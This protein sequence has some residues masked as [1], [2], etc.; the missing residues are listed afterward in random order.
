MHTDEKRKL[1]RF[2]F[3]SVLIGVPSVALFLPL[4]FGSTG[5]CDRGGGGRTQNRVVLYTSVDDPVARPILAEFTKRTGIEV[6]LRTDTEANKSAGLVARLEAEKSNPRADVWWGN[7]IFRTINLADRGVL[8]PYESPAA[9]DIPARF[10]DP[11][12]L[13]AGSAQRAR[14]IAL[15]ADAE[16]SPQDLLPND[17]IE[18]LVHPAL[19]GRV[20]LADPRAGTTSGH[21]AAL[22]VLWGEAKA[23]QFFRRLRA[24]GAK[25]LGGNADVAAEVGRGTV[26]VGL[27]DNDDL[28]HAASGGARIEGVLPD[29]Q[30]GGAGTLTIPCTVAL[31]AGGKN[32]EGAKK[33]IDYLL[34]AEV[35]ERL[36]DAKFAR[37][38]V[39]DDEGASDE[40]RGAVD[41]VKPMNVDYRQ[42]AKVLPRAARSAHAI[43]VGRE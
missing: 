37:Y 11:S 30:H 18:D 3:V 8:A 32:P 41:S 35:E 39:R 10:K 23:E 6:D 1:N 38:S 28:S 40:A 21:V 27:T 19:K 36:I 22:Y 5:G 15:H 2:R 16:Q 25:V 14:V 26:W 20:A 9:A 17:S 42:V 4:F 31:V 13:W 33:L 43:L 24:N 29:Q 12:H 34:S 7:E